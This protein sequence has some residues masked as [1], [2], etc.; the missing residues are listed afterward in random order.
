MIWLLSPVFDYFRSTII[1]KLD[2]KILYKQAL[3]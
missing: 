2:Y 1:Y 3:F